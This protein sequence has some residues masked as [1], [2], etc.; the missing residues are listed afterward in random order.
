LK[1]KPI[2][3]GEGADRI[4]AM[5][6][7]D[8][9][10]LRSCTRGEVEQHRFIWPRR[11]VSLEIA[12]IPIAFGKASPARWRHVSHNHAR[13]VAVANIYEFR[14]L[15]LVGNDKT[16][17]P[18]FNPIANLLRG[19]ESR[20]WNHNGAK[21]DGRKHRLPERHDITKEEKQMVAA[22]E[23]KSAQVVGNLIR[24][25]RKLKEAELDLLAG[26]R[27]N[28]PQCGTVA[29]FRGSGKLGIEPI[30]RPVE[31]FGRRPAEIR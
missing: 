27:L 6:V 10:G 25:S 14:D 24:T 19:E 20:G 22:L 11:R 8:E 17:L 30:E 2:H 23:A 9:F 5:G 13:Q 12:G 16:N 15:V 21:L 31:R 1:P 3:G 29:T 26:R 4:A 7:P 28:D 18:S